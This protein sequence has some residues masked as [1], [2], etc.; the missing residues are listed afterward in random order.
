MKIYGLNIGEHPSEFE[1]GYR[2]GYYRG[3]WYTIDKDGEF[4]KTHM[5]YHTSQ[6]YDSFTKSREWLEFKD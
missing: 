5:N 1:N 3:N 6:L 2:I 4:K